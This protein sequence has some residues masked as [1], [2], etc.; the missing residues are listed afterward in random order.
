MKRKIVM[1][2]F[3][4]S[5]LIGCS[6][7]DSTI[8]EV[9]FID[10]LAEQK[11]FIETSQLNYTDAEDKELAELAMSRFKLINNNGDLSYV[12]ISNNL[13]DVITDEQ[14]TQ[15]IN[16]KIT[17]NNLIDDFCTK[18]A[19]ATF[20]TEATE[21]DGKISTSV[22]IA[23]YVK[24]FVNTQR[25]YLDSLSELANS[26]TYKSIQNAESLEI[27]NYVCIPYK[28]DSAYLLLNITN[29][30]E[31][32]IIGD[33]VNLNSDTVVFENKFCSL[34]GTLDVTYFSEEEISV[35]P[36]TNKTFSF[37]IDGSKK[38]YWYDSDLNNLYV[39]QKVQE[40]SKNE[41]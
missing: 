19:T 41:E 1:L 5:L 11:F 39:V 40:E 36:N 17:N 32:K 9:Y 33:V 20:D 10:D 23:E 15:Y 37:D 38:I 25:E 29:V 28:K 22:F 34:S 6:N 21:V 27:G 3:G 30:T 16:G 18:V 7:N 31:D 24:N 4:V 26:D 2:L 35:E 12:G 8:K 13:A 14:I